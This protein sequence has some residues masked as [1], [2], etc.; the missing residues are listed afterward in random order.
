MA[1]I[2]P[3]S[4]DGYDYTESELELPGDVVIVT[5]TETGPVAVI[6][7]RQLY[8]RNQAISGAERIAS[9]E[10]NTS[11]GGR[12]SL[13]IS[14][15]RNPS[16][17]SQQWGDQDE[18]QELNSFDVVKDIKSAPYFE[19][20][21]NDQ[22][23]AVVKKFEGPTPGVDSG[24]TDLQKSLYG[25]LAHG[26]ESY[27][28]TAHEF[29]QTFQTN[30]NRLLKAATSNPNTVQDPPAPNYILKRLI[31]AL[32]DGEWLKKPTTVQY[33]GRKGFLVSLTYHWAPKWSVIYGG[34][35]TGLDPVTP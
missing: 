34:T 7:A 35:F 1:E 18:L 21:T 6:N 33:V 20:L 28:E 25:H 8:W 14:F 24:W 17:I 4:A 10:K 23:I 3:S 32:P 9:L 19:D 31:D 26:Q 30:S 5:R 13:T 12:A 29:R 16:I 11:G 15:D 22:V 27:L 2:L